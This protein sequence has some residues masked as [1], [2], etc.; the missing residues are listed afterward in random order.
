MK[1]RR[2]KI[3][4]TILLL[5][6]ILIPLGVWWLINSETASRWVLQQA[7]NQL[8]DQISVETINRPLREGLEF[9]QLKFHSDSQTVAMQDFKLDWQLSELVSGTLKINQISINGVTVELLESKEEES[10]F[11][12]QAKIDLPLNVAIDDF[13]LRHLTVKQQDSRYQLDSL[14]FTAFTQDNKL[15]L[16]SLK[17]QGMGLN[18]AVTAQSYIGSGFAFTAA[19]TWQYNHAEYGEFRGKLKAD[20]NSLAV[21]FDNQLL[22]PFKLSQQGRVENLMQNPT[23]V[24][25]GAWQNLRYPLTGKLIQLS[26]P[27]GDFKASGSAQAYQLELNALLKPDKF[28]QANLAFNSSGTAQGLQIKQLQLRT[29]SGNLQVL[30]HVGWEKGTQFDLAATASHFNPAV[31]A[32]N[33]SGDLNMQT[34][35][36]GQ[37]SA[38]K[39]LLDIDIAYLKGTLRN[40]PLFATGKLQLKDKDLTVK[41]FT[42]NSGQNKISAQGQLGEKTA[43]LDIA[44]N[45]P[46]LQSLWKGLSGQLNANAHLQGELTHPSLQL[47]AEGK[48]L[49][50]N[51]HA[52]KQFNITAD[53]AA[54]GKKSSQLK[55]TAAELSSGVHKISKFALSGDGFLS[56][57]NFHTVLNSTEGDLELALSGVWKDNRWQSRLSQLKLYQ[58]QAGHWQLKQ[59]SDVFL[60]KLKQGVDVALSESCFSQNAAFICVQ[61]SYP[62]NGNFQ[63]AVRAM[64][65]THLAKPYFPSGLEFNSQLHLQANARKNGKQM[66]GTYQLNLTKNS[67]LSIKVKKNLSKLVLNTL[68]LNGTLQGTRVNSQLELVYNDNNYLRGQLGFDT[69]NQQ[70]MN[71]QFSAAVLDFS[72]LAPY[73]EPLSE[74]Q[75]NL[76]AAVSL[77]G[78]LS[79]PAVN[80]QVL[81]NNTSVK[82]EPAGIQLTGMKLKLQNQPDNPN[83]VLINGEV[84]SGAGKLT[85]SGKTQLQPEQGFP[86]QLSIL[87]TDFEAVQLPQANITLAPDLNFSYNKDGG[88]LSGKIVV[89]QAKIELVELPKNAVLP[90]EDE[91]IIGE[92]DADTETKANQPPAPPFA[93][94]VTLD[95]G[96]SASFKG[97]GMNT[98]LVGKLLLDK[99]G[100]TLAMHGEV[101]LE[102]GRYKSY[103]QDLTMRRGKFIFNG[104]AVNP[105][106]DIEAT[107]LSK[108]KLITAVLKVTG[109]LQN[110]KT[111]I[112]TEPEVPEADALAYLITGNSINRLSK[113]EG[114]M[115]ASA[116]LSLGAGQM[117][118]L[119]EKFGIDEMEIEE[120][121]NLKDSLLSI[122]QYLTPDFYVG[123]RMGLFNKQTSIVTKY[124]F[125]DSLSIGTQ[126]GDSQRVNLNYEFSLE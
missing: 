42:L 10:D 34:Q 58:A 103:G 32:A 62:A 55:F 106:L 56:K 110:P 14:T 118:W 84:K 119:T 66:N 50:F 16:P 30:G 36:R 115:L 82:V 1:F 27:Q 98:Q 70:T 39:L 6:L 61:G 105:L 113:S 18:A 57:H 77:G 33:I 93:V 67:P 81:L 26:S 21:N 8:K 85:L 23:L 51:E 63:G 4:L 13:S 107:R 117:S 11:D 94:N 89:N 60:T 99:R 71:G 114:S 102:N 74:L 116:A 124:K 78:T 48:Q 41:N 24:T 92:T 95:L 73:I 47:K 104:S 69:A 38:E 126:S 83:Q 46:Q 45:A 15:L 75:G 90:S 22:A 112:Y 37:M 20:G 44:V 17:V 111:Q 108:S 65:P 76:T 68:T 25:H 31:V 3:A 109:D 96:K 80:G 64:L 35:L 52:V 101:I 125:T 5:L 59:P 87:G 7:L 123:A 100:E 9:H 49:R 72:L 79:K 29:S 28:P 121:E 53:Y 86:T 40:Y 122:G 12:P 2:L 88:K 91:E 43:K 19:L 54:D 120:G 97:L